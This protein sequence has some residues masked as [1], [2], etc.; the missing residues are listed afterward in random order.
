MYDKVCSDNKTSYQ[1][2]DMDDHQPSAELPEESDTL[3]GEMSCYFSNEESSVSMVLPSNS[4][5]LTRNIF[6]DDHRKYLLKVCGSMVKSGVI[7][8]IVVKDLLS[9]DEEGKEL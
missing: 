2:S 9:K 5:Y 4:S 6:T 3:A 8:Q 1:H 7:S